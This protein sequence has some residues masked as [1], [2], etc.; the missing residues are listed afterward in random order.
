M[1]YVGL[2]VAPFWNDAEMAAAPNSGHMLLG[3]VA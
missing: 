1:V 2:V 3:P